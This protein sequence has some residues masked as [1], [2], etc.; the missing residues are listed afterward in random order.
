MAE[1]SSLVE[2]ML[3]HL[4]NGEQQKAEELF[5]DYVVAKSRD[6][7][8]SL[9][10]SEIAEGDDEDE[11]EEDEKEEEVEEGFDDEF[12]EADATDDLAGELDM[13]D[14]EGDMGDMGDDEGGEESEEEIMQD[15][16]DIIDE[17]Q[18]KFDALSSS[19]EEQGEFD[20][21]GDMGDMGD[22]EEMKDDIELE[23]VR[24]YVER[25]PAGHGAE[26][27]GAAEK[28]DGSATGLKFSK[29]D[30]G[31]TTA[32]ILSGRNGADAGESGAGGK[33]KGS[34][35]SD[36]SPQEMKTGNL[37][38]VGGFKGDAFKKNSAGHGAEKKGSAEGSTDG[39]SL[40]R[41][42]R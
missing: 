35:L 19:E 42:R 14:D 11:K 10:E 6:I 12:A 25:V 2:Q 41:G 34:A 18:A 17:L 13:G 22:D 32:N 36:T 4:V 39:T 15:L 40:F 31:G 1:K 16:G 37:N 30:M 5:H 28:A 3:E 27:K 7:Y 20:D 26:K 38:T 29:N 21:E 8:E 24:E 9:I 33:I 23:T